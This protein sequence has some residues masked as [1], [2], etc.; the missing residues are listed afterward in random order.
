[1]Q[2]RR[3]HDACAG[4]RSV[5][6]LHQ[7]LRNIVRFNRLIVGGHQR[8]EQGSRTLSALLA[9]AWRRFQLMVNA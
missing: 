8:L 2:F 3:Q 5:N 6:R 9:D 4:M 7:R 1:M